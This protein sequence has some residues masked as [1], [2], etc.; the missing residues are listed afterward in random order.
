MQNLFAIVALVFAAVHLD[1]ADSAP[2]NLVG[3]V[4]AYD[5]TVAGNDAGTVTFD[6]KYTYFSNGDTPEP[7]LYEKVSPASFRVVN[8]DP[9]QPTNAWSYLLFT[10]TTPTAG[11]IYDEDERVSKGIFQI[12]PVASP[13]LHISRLVPGQ[14][15]LTATSPIGQIIILEQST[16]LLAWLPIATNLS[17]A[18][19]SETNLPI[20]S[21]KTF[22]RA[23]T[24]SQ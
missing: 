4:L 9:A 12:F 6:A 24:P 11:T 17:W 8:F 20:A 21:P 14:A 22:F 1:A 15:R 2:L 7:Y 19:L 3:R 18:G 10:F 5:Q 16:N 13:S 23:F